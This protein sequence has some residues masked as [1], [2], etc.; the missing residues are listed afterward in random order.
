MLGESGRDANVSVCFR[1]LFLGG[2]FYDAVSSSDFDWWTGKNL[3][4]KGRGLI[5][6]LSVNFR[7]GAEDFHQQT[8]VRITHWPGQA[9]LE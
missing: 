3:D 6:V 4:G 8:A 5:E 9:S 1:Y 7:G 2:L